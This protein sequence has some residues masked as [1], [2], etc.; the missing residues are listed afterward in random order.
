MAELSAS[1][2]GDADGPAGARR[3]VPW[4]DVG[5]CGLLGVAVLVLHPLSYVLQ[6]PYWLDEAWVA[7]ASRA[8]MSQVRW[9]SSS[10]PL[11][12]L[13]LVRAVPG[14][15]GEQL[16]VVPLVFSVGVVI[17]AYVLARSLR[18]PSIML[19]RIA[20]VTAA[21]IVLFAPT[22]LHRNDLKQYTADGFF[23]LVIVALALRVDARRDRR[24]VMQL[25]IV[26]VIAVLFSS[27]SAFVS[28]AVFA[29][30]AV[31]TATSRSGRSEEHTSE[32]QS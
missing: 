12:W 21:A 27:T 6:H 19:A 18:W 23:A 22:S 11:G 14:S 8:P 28:V 16:R 9:V 17:V 5:I 2:A 10:T 29:G 7:A 26:C 30:L 20:G 1:L 31:T 15:R 25:A 24:A 13:L 32:L 3:V 4:A